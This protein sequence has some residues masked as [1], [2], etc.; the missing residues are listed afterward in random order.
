MKILF[1]GASSFTG[2]WFVSKLAER[3][4]E[5]WATFTQTSAEAYGSDIRGQRVRRL[6]DKCQPLFSCRF[7]DERFLKLLNDEKFELLCHHAA[8]VTNYKS[9]DF[10]VAR[11]VANNTFRAS[12]VLQSLQSAGYSL[13]LTGSIFE[14]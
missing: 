3:G 5:G 4:H 14:P 12:D 2:H 6:L 9:P 11:A 7:G 13:L 10:D 8:D 1:T